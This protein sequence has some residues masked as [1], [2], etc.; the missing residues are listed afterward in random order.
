MADEKQSTATTDEDIAR[1]VE[2][3]EPGVDSAMRVLELSEQ[4]YYEA[5]HQLAAAPVTIVAVSH[6]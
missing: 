1:I 2:A 5:A 3:G 6:T 4:Y